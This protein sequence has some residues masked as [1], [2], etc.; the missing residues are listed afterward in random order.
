MKSVIHEIRNQPKHVREL[1]TLLC[2]I[3]VVA[4]VGLVWFRSFQKDMYAMLN[5]EQA[6]AEGGGQ[7]QLFA[8]QSKSLFG[9]IFQILS[10]GKTQISSLFNKNQTD[11]TNGQASGDGSSDKATHPL[12]IVKDR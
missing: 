2:T 1:A 9:S 3:A 5:P 11:V 10:D 7:D 4:V 8:Q 12:P 6:G